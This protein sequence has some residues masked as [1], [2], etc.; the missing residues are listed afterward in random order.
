MQCFSIGSSQLQP[1]FTLSLPE[2]Y[3]WLSEPSKSQIVHSSHRNICSGRAKCRRWIFDAVRAAP[4]GDGA[5]RGD[6][7]GQPA[8]RPHNAPTTRCP[9]LETDPTSAFSASGD[10]RRKTGRGLHFSACSK[11]D[12]CGLAKEAYCLY[13]FVNFK[14]VQMKNV[15]IIFYETYSRMV[16]CSL[17]RIV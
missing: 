11:L 13:P 15:N 7:H 2:P 3:L 8:M 1:V 6:A 5:R 12:W 14:K 10:F 16:F 4:R 9:R 17:L